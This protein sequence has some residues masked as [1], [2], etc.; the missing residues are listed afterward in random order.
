MYHSKVMNFVYYCACAIT[1]EGYAQWQRN[2]REATTD[3]Q[4]LA[5]LFPPISFLQ[6]YLVI[7]TAVDMTVSSWSGRQVCFKLSVQ[8]VFKF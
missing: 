6:L 7:R 1:Y 5:N 8:F 3:Q 2:Y 4:K